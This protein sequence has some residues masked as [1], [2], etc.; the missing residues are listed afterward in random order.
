MSATWA[1]DSGL[2]SGPVSC[3]DYPRKRMQRVGR[4][5][6]ASQTGGSAQSEQEAVRLRRHC[7]RAGSLAIFLIPLRT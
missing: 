7:R 5:S 3:A 2:W 4:A 6:S 1:T